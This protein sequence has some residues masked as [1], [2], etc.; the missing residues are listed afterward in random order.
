L[1]DPSWHKAVVFDA[2]GTLI[3]PKPSAASVYARVARRFGSRL[4]TAEIGERFRVAFGRQDDIDRGNGWR[5]DEA[6]ERDRWRAIVYEVLDDVNDPEACFE[7][8]YLHFEWPEAWEVDLLAVELLE[9][10]DRRGLKLGVASN[11]D[12]R[13]HTVV[14]GW[15]CLHLLSHRIVSSEVG[16]RKPAPEF[17]AAIC[18]VTGLAP[19]QIA[20]IGDD[21]ENDCQA[22]RRAGMNAIWLRNGCKKRPDEDVL[23]VQDLAGL[24]GFRL[25]SE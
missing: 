23:Q 3:H 1:L 16:W 14:T 19:E 10:L 5:T 6:R 11:F 2:V 18:D 7:A 17:F 12:S 13:L 9:A 24:A 20:Y 22:A 21:W 25:L 15:T 4:R 8:L